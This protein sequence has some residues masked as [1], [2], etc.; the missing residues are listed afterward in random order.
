MGLF[1]SHW[2]AARQFI[3]ISYEV[4]LA[5]TLKLSCSAK[6]GVVS[7]MQ[8]PLPKPCIEVL[9]SSNASNPFIYEHSR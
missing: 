5:W 9:H 2:K 6:L 7:S 4:K 3:D 8:S 1:P